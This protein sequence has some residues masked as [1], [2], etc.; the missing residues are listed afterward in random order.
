MLECR[1]Q[2]KYD[3][4]RACESA[5][6]EQESERQAQKD[7]LYLPG[8]VQHQTPVT[9]QLPLLNS[10]LFLSGEYHAYVRFDEH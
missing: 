6:V 10:I 7:V 9:A 8:R 5:G 1:L 2:C 4:W 3:R